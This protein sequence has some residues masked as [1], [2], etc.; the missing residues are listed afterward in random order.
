[1]M[2]KEVNTVFERLKFEKQCL[3]AQQIMEMELKIPI[4]HWDFQE[5]SPVSRQNNIGFYAEIKFAWVCLVNRGSTSRTDILR[6]QNHRIIISFRL[7]E[8]LRIIWFQLFCCGLGRSRLGLKA[9]FNLASNTFREGI[10][11]TYLSNMFWCLSILITI[12][13]LCLIYIYSL[14]F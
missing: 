11:T 13:S 10:H 6:P 8:I 7:E 2:V 5:K 1:M 14:L 3:C 4:L 12:F 9:P